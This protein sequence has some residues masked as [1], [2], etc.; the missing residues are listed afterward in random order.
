MLR[1]L[2]DAIAAALERRRAAAVHPPRTA[3]VERFGA[4]LQLETPRALAFVDR[5]FARTVGVTGGAAW[6]DPDDDGAL[7]AHVLSAP[8]E[9]HLQLTNR[10][11]AGCTGCYTGASPSGAPHEWELA[12]WTRAIDA[13]ADAG[14]FH[15]ALGGGE[16]AALPW[17]GALALHARRRGM[18]PNLTTSGLD[19]LGAL[20]AIAHRFGQINVSLDGLR[21]AYAAVRGFDGFA[22]ADDAIRALRSVKTEIGINVVVTRANFDQLGAL[23]A[24]AADRRLAEVELLR[25]KPAGRGARAYDQLRCTDAQH[26]ALL[27]AILAAAKQH[28]MRVKVDCSYTPMLAHHAPSRALLAQLAV[29]GCTGGDFLVGAKPGGQL[30][31]CS[32]AAPPPPNAAGARPKAHELASYWT[33]PDAFGAFRTWRAAA[34]PCASCEYHA[35]CRGG[36]KVVSAHVTG[37]LSAPDPECPRVVDHARAGSPG[38]SARVHLPVI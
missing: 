36:C 22:R 13:L 19:G 25:F 5:A 8:L 6:R 14:V 9:A 24:Y 11:N 16:S 12:E 1:N 2:A 23:F 29:Y 7:G 31:A 18:I 30:T 32:F 37:V 17:L 35:L 38:P 33:S 3:R 20:L 21:D 4:V 34:E 10:C 28:R 27:P 26:R 15:V